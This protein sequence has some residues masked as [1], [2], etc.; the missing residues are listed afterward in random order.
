MRLNGK[1]LFESKK[2]KYLGLIVDDRFSWKFH[3]K[4]LSKKLCRAI[5][6]I[7]WTVL[8]VS[9]SPFIVLFFS[10]NY[11]M[12]YN[13]LGIRVKTFNWKNIFI[14]KK[15]VQIISNALY[16]AHTNLSSKILKSLIFGFSLNINL[17]IQNPEVL[18][19]LFVN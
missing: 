1:T 14:T 7:I 13:G 2:I 19:S 5:G 10:H 12:G 9:F 3:I 11:L 16:T 6:V 17:E 4:E 18:T 8:K 15:A